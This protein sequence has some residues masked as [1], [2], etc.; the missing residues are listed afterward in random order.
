MGR[1]AWDG[2]GEGPLA[3]RV[4][5]GPPPASYAIDASAA[6]A[7]RDERGER[8]MATYVEARTEAART[9]AARN[10]G[11]PLDLARV[12]GVRVNRSAVERRAATLPARRTVQKE[13]QAAVLLP[14]LAL[15]DLTPL[16]GDATPRTPPR[17]SA[18]C[19]PP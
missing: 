15:L 18:N 1:P 5:A 6:D 11:M 13:W 9:D 12:E 17:P 16:S 4:V 7:G 19:T 2:Q 8:T 3:A 10:P 14:A